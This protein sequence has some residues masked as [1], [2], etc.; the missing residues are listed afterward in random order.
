MSS[1]PGP[2]D[3]PRDCPSDPDLADELEKNIKDKLGIGV[4]R[5]DALAAVPDIPV[6]F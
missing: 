6:D 5:V 3:S 1:A 4:P 2:S